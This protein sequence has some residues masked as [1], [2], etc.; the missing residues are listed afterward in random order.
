[1]SNINA[2]VFASYLMTVLLH[3]T[4]FA[5]VIGVD[6]ERVKKCSS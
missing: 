5:A 4:L 6:F 2:K 3:L 1:M